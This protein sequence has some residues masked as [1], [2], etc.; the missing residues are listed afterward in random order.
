M[1]R[2][3]VTMVVVVLLVATLSMQTAY[4][5]AEAVYEM[6]FEPYHAESIDLNEHVPTVLLEVPLVRQSTDYSCGVACTQS[7]LRYSGYDF[8]VREDNLAAALGASSEHG[9][10]Y[11]EI[12]ELLNT[13]S[14]YGDA[15]N[16]EAVNRILAEAK[17]NLT[18]DALCA[19]LDQG[20]PVICAI[21]AWA[22]LTADEYESE[23]D[24]GHYVIAI[25]YDDVNIYF[26]DPS[27]AGNYAYIPKDEFVA[28][29]HDVDGEDA[30]E[31]F[32]IVITMEAD[33]AKNVAFKME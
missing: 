30:V 3:I 29:W 21:Q 4:E 1:I 22:Y 28:R 11:E 5:A 8:D 13:K 25:G 6:H 26:M 14:H 9:T 31:Q 16:D 27:T 15:K 2:K 20:K 32:G 7:I 19:Y 12:V 23:I 18:V 24:S 33:Y 10:R 17:F